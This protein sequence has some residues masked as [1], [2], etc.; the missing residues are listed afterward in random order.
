[1]AKTKV[2]DKVKTKGIPTGAVAVY[3]TDKGDVYVIPKTGE[4]VTT[5][6]ARIG[7]AHNKHAREAVVL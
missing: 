5:A 7:A 2:K 1:M 4:A 3:R 6:I